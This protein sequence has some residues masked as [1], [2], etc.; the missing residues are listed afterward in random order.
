LKYVRVAGEVSRRRSMGMASLPGVSNDIDS[1]LFSKKD[2]SVSARLR[3][4][5]WTSLV[6]HTLCNEPS[7]QD[8]RRAPS[9]CGCADRVGWCSGSGG[10]RAGL[11]GAHERVAI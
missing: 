9:R 11:H 10:R 2:A 6:T 7:R 4:V 1:F 3:Q 5:V 8:R